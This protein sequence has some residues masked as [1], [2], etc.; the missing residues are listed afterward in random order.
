[1]GKT[2][3][4]HV[5][6]IDAL[7]PCHVIGCL[8]R[9]P[10]QRKS[11]QAALASCHRRGSG[12]AKIP[13]SCAKNCTSTL[14]SAQR[15]VVPFVVHTSAPPVS[16][17]NE[18]RLPCRGHRQAENLAHGESFRSHRLG[19]EAPSRGAAA[20]PSRFLS[21][22]CATYSGCASCFRLLLLRTHSPTASF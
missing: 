20:S 2:N 3:L 9:P 7:Y 21:C 8:M 18:P 11:H 12:T 5:V 4:R 10:R 16:V 13:L 19:K 17:W 14:S 15:R 6:H 22:R 1:M